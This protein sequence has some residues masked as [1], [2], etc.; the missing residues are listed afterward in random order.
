[1]TR[2]R[3][4]SIL[5]LLA[6]SSMVK[7][8]DLTNIERRI[9]G[10]PAYRSK[11]KY[12][13]LALGPEAKTRIWLV[14][15]GDTLYVDRNGNGDL[16]ETN[17]K[18]TARRDENDEDGAYIFK[19]GHLPDGDRLHKELTLHINRRGYSLGL[20]VEMRGF[21][22]NGIGGRVHQSTSFQ[23]IT[24]VLQF[25]ERPKDAPIVHFGGPFQITLFGS[26]QLMVDREND[27]GVGVTTR[28]LG[29]GTFVWTDYE[30]VIPT[31]RFPTLDL[32]Y[33]PKH[34]GDRPLREHY[35]LKK[36]C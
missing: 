21:R 7:A 17:E 5:L 23:D 2:A 15:D 6:L 3:P 36:R 19:A 28:G 10:E 22:G 4:L 8:D 18:V 9:V 26:H 34:P 16:T 20:D 1:M 31:D 12:C 25:A 32:V 30:N 24:G 11:P 27:V 13:L 29:P 14:Q 33:P 35:E